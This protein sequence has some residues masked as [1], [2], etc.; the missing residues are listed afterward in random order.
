MFEIQTGDENK[1]LRKVCAPVKIFDEK[2]KSTVEEMIETM[3]TPDPKT[4][5]KGI[6]IAANQCGVDA[7]ILILTLN[8]H[9]DKSDK[10]HKICAMVNPEVLEFSKNEVFM[11]EGCLSVP[12]KY[13][14]IKR[15]AKVKVRWKN[16]AGDFCEKKFDGWD[17][18]IFLH[19]LDHL[20]G[21]LF[22][23]YL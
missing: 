15:A 5:V 3:T 23:D 8:F 4:D 18:R 1:I 19:E 2:L 22:T 14:P 6:G 20:N 16:V 10:N 21:K 9:P 7:R 17:A 11:E 12:E 13:A